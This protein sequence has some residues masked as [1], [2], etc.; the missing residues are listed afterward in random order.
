MYTSQKLLCGWIRAGDSLMLGQ[1]QRDFVKPEIHQSSSPQ[2]D[3]PAK[4]NPLI[5]I[6]R[7]SFEGTMYELG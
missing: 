5:C 7:S 6:H 1:L 4:K 2:A 3:I